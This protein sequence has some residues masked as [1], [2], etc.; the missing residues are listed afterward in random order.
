[1]WWHRGVGSGQTVW[2]QIPALP[3]RRVP[4]SRY[5]KIGLAGVPALWRGLLQGKLIDPCP[6]TPECG[7]CMRPSLS[8]DCNVD[9]NVS[10][11]LPDL[12]HQSRGDKRDHFVNC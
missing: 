10:P 4:V 12:G 1:M 3:L 7:H 5:H 9:A 8:G 11:A 2:L 6:E